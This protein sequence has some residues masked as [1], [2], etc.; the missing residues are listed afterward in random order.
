MP[1]EI[2]SLKR[3]IA[4]LQQLFRD[5]SKE[6]YDCDKL[7]KELEQE[8]ADRR[9]LSERVDELE[10]VAIK[11]LRRRVRENKSEIKRD[12]FHQFLLSLVLV[13]LICAGFYFFSVMKLEDQQESAREVFRNIAILIGGGV[14]AVYG[15]EK[16]SSGK[17]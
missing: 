14:G 7:I 16:L 8:K 15:F 10:M 5:Q 13:A 9:A 11:E 1:D 6:H 4:A 17:K 2:A 3:Q 12:R